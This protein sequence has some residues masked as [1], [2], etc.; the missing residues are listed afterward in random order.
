MKTV[1]STT[2]W[3]LVLL[4]LLLGLL[5]CPPGVGVAAAAAAVGLVQCPAF[6]SAAQCSGSNSTNSA[7]LHYSA[8]SVQLCG[9]Q[10]VHATT[11]G[12]HSSDINNDSDSDSGSDSG[13]SSCWGDTFLRVFSA[14]GL[15]VAFNDNAAQHEDDNLC[16]EL[17]FSLPRSY[18][19]QEYSF[20]LGCAGNQDHCA[21]QLLVNVS[22]VSRMFVRVYVCMFVCEGD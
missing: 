12:V 6:D 13:S 5:V 21:G 18:G 8:C 11:H 3:T 7:L 20:H 17:S 22:G 16:S 9:G 2:P 4:F 1:A 15:E 14:E 19:C 10:R